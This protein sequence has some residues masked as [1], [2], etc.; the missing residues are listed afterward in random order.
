VKGLEPEE[1]FFSFEDSA[2]EAEPVTKR[3]GINKNVKE[4]NTSSRG[5]P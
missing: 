2:G 4:K 5:M 3:H 1:A